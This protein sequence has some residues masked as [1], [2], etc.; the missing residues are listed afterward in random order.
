M[1]HPQ[2]PENVNVFTG[3]ISGDTASLDRSRRALM[4]IF[5]PA[6]IETPVTDFTHTDYYRAEMGEG[7]KRQFL[8]FRALRPLAGLYRAKLATNRIEEKLAVASRDQRGRLIRRRSVN[9]DPGYL[10]LS[11]VVLFTTKDFTHRIYL[12]KGIYAEVTLTFRK[13]GCA[14]FDW[15]Y[16]D[17]RSDRYKAFFLDVRRRYLEDVETP[18]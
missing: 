17:Y 6:D 12:D 5:G 3:L 14:Y 16:P 7:L 13:N 18:I 9:I 8:G 15:T 10:D 1:G 11:K 2:R 4:R